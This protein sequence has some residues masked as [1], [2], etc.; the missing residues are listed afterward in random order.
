[1]RT[2][3][4][5][6]TTGRFVLIRGS[7][8]A[9]L[10]HLF[11]ERLRTR[12]PATPAAKIDKV[13]RQALAAPLVIAVGAHLLPEHK[14]PELEQLLSTGASVMNLLNAFHLQ[15]YGAVWLTGGNAY[16]SEIAAALGFGSNETCLG[17]VYVGSVDRANL[18][19]P[20]RSQPAA[21]VREWSDSEPSK[22][23]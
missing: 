23:G 11:A 20:R 16:D 9:R 1:M 12:E 17:F 2:R 21:Q 15:G 5:Y 4:R 10:A 3:S 7:A 19:P 13:Q 8:R 6:A 22:V 18:P 14:I